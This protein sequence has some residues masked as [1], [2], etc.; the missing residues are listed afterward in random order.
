[1]FAWG[2]SSGLHLVLDS[3]AEGLLMKAISGTDGAHAWA[4]GKR[5]GDRLAGMSP[6]RRPATSVAAGP[7]STAGGGR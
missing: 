6:R 7:E 3:P 5:R 2:A 4:N 1:M